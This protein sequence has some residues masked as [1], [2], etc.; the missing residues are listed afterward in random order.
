MNN[1]KRFF[2]ATNWL[3]DIIYDQT[4]NESFC[5]KLES[6]QYKAALAKTG[7]IQGFFRKKIYQKLEIESF[8]WYRSLSFMLKIM[9][10]KASNYV[11]NLIS[12]CEQTIRTRNNHI[13]TNKCQTDRFL[14]CFSSTTLNHWLSL[15]IRNS[16]SILIF[17]SS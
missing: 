13:P 3:G 7:V 12:K 15:N 10:E 14:F 11:I 5:E 17:N 6:V 1:I 16:V 4:Q 9:K 2:E 8:K